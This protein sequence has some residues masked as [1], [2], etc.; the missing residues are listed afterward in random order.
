MFDEV[1]PV[2]PLPALPPRRVRWPVKVIFLS[3]VQQDAASEP[4]SYWPLAMLLL[5]TA[6]GGAIRFFQLAVPTLW[7]DEVQAYWRVCGT[8]GQMLNVLRS[9][10]FPPLHYSL[11]WVIGR[12]VT[13][14]P[15]YIRLGPALSGTLMIPAMYFLAR[16]LLPRST[17]LLAAALVA[18]SA[19][20]MFYSRDGKMYAHAWL[21]VVLNVG[22]LLWWF[23]TGRST[24]WLCWI[25]AGCAMVGFHA[26][27]FTVLALSPVLFLT[28]RHVHWKNAMLLVLGAVLIAAG[29][30]GYYLKFN[31]F[32]ENVEERG[33]RATG[34]TW[35]NGFNG[36]RTG[37][38]HVQYTATSFL[39]GYE[40]PRPEFLPDIPEP[41]VTGPQLAATEIAILLALGA[42]PWPRML[43][44]KPAW[45][46]REERP[47]RL[48]LWLGCWIL[49]PGYIFYCHSVRNFASPIQWIDT[50]RMWITPL[51]QIALAAASG[52]FVVAG[53]FFKPIRGAAARLIQYLF[54][55]AALFGLCM[56]AFH[57]CESAAATADQIDRPWRSIWTPRYL[58]FTWP[59][60]ILSV[61][62][63]LMRLPTRA[64]ARLGN[65]VCA[66]RESGDGEP[67]AISSDRTAGRQNGR[68]RLGITAG[69]CNC[70]HVHVS[71]PQ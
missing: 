20:A 68:R 3:E 24:A 10:G 63:L 65:R 70:P 43:R 4:R 27:T 71:H 35:V 22:C 11:L 69:P 47:W 49:I 8:Y 30:A 9:D 33:W 26:S 52:V 41:L 64:P 50:L 25:A 34:I 48:L 5:L 44:R 37:P 55:L 15:F 16:Q 38:E 2:L 54:V 31:H 12:F 32:V 1:K 46:G 36:N 7:N 42:L 13:L 58:G 56:A 67:A 29:P 40:W 57:I 6:F 14:T 62:V 66:G 21:F 28:Q 23:R 53:L 61:A 17:S 19:F 59:A 39:M 18:C 51:E 60:V 45:D